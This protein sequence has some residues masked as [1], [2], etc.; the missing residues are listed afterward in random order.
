M[1]AKSSKLKEKLLNE[2][3]ELEV[4]KST[5]ISEFEVFKKTKH[6]ELS[7]YCKITK[8]NADSELAESAKQ[9]S[10]A[11][12][13]LIQVNSE[14]ARIQKESDEL[15]NGWNLLQRGYEDLKKIEKTLKDQDSKIQSDLTGLKFEQNELEKKLTLLSGS[16][17]EQDNIKNKIKLEQSSLELFRE[18]SLRQRSDAE[19]KIHE[20]KTAQAEMRIKMEMIRKR[21]EELEKQKTNVNALMETLRAKGNEIERKDKDLKEM[22]QNLLEEKKNIEL[23]KRKIDKLAKV[24]DLE[25]ELMS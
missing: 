15:K 14:G 9:S 8:K 1:I 12:G 24:K 2:I 10:E 5:F 7:D 23:L 6:E 25:K 3:Q 16:K 4:K 11:A 20:A 21:E 13:K 19:E 17:A 22:S 18:D